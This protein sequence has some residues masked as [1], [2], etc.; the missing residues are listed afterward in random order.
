MNLSAESLDLPAFPKTPDSITQAFVLGAG[1]GTRLKRLTATRPKPLVPLA[2]RPLIASAFDHLIGAGIRSIAVNTHHC[3]EAYA[4]AFPERTY[5]GVPLTFRHEPVLLET[6]GGIKN[7]EDLLGGGPFIVYNG[8]VLSTLPLEPAIDHHFAAG[9]EVTLILR[10]QGEALH[11][12]LEET[13]RT[14]SGFTAGRVADIRERLGRA[15]GTH[16]FTGLYLVNPAFLKRLTPGKASVI[17][18]FL[19]MIEEG[20]RLN[21]LGAIIIDEGEW[22]D[23]GTREQ[24]LAAQRRLREASP[25]ECWVHPTASVAADARITGASFIGAGSE[26]G[27]GARLHDTILWEGTKIAPDSVLENCIV[28][29]N[30]N[31]G[32]VHFD[33]DL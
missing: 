7:V 17:P 29:E 12:A 22:W 5:R 25:G 15:P 16:L 2:G 31:V 30:Q 1:L 11:I 18:T 24:L 4:G 33:A 23:L 28:T 8:D 26:V 9:N 20:N 13:G 21:G 10:S 3:S 27:R 14:G 6:G 32:G 19:E